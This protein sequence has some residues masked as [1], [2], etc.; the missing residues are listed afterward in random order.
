MSLEAVF[1][2]NRKVKDLNLI[3]HNCWAKVLNQLKHKLLFGVWADYVNQSK[4]ARI[5]LLKRE[6][7][8][9]IFI[10]K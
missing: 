9:L 3:S 7:K 6:S 1:Q 4:I 10:G 8:T 2:K 5:I